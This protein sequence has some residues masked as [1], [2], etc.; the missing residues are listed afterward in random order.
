MMRTGKLAT[1]GTKG[2]EFFVLFVPF[3]ANSLRLIDSVQDCLTDVFLQF[4]A[5]RE[6]EHSSKAV[7]LGKPLLVVD[8][9]F[10]AEV[11][12]IRPAVTLDQVHRVAMR[13]TGGI[14][15]SSVVE[16]HRIDDQRIAFPF[17]DG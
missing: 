5:G 8:G 1:K 17:A 2:T 14:E 9:E 10:D 6:C 15:P 3:V 13:F 4:P 16:T 12:E 11:T 7:W